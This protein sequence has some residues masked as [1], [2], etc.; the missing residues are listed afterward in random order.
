MAKQ[1]FVAIVLHA[2]LPYVRHPEHEKSLEERW[3]FEAIWECILPLLELLDR[4][5]GDGIEGALTLSISPPL[6]AMLCDPLLMWRFET[7]LE[8]LQELAQRAQRYYR[9]RAGNADL[10]QA[11]LF[12]AARLAQAKE[13]LVWRASILEVFDFPG[14]MSLREAIADRDITLAALGLSDAV[15]AKLEALFKNLK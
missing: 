1:G 3:L 6:A 12:C 14:R 5:R 13:G 10:A 8:H 9:D 4:L 2:H 11:A 7:Y 15:K